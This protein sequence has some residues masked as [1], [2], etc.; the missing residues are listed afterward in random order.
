MAMFTFILKFGFTSYTTQLS[1]LD[2]TTVFCCNNLNLHRK[3]SC[4]GL[5][6]MGIYVLLPNKTNPKR[7]AFYEQ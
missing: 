3:I 5:S 6:F 4:K 7:K 1:G 2:F